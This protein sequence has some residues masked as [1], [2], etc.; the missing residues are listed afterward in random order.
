MSIRPL[1]RAADQVQESPRVLRYRAGD[2][3]TETP[4]PHRDP[5]D[6]DLVEYLFISLPSLTS[7]RFVANALAALEE[8][9]SIRILD[10]IV[11]VRKEDD[12]LEVFELDALEALQP[13][14]GRPRP[15]G[16]LLSDR[17]IKLLALGVKPATTGVIVVIESSWA[18]P[19]ARAART[20][21]GR[22]VAGERIP[23]PRFEAVRN[24]SS[25]DD[26]IE[27]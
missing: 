7:L 25:I 23:R 26:G 27:S 17:D 4:E 16:R 12:A 15:F 8:A 20:G 14:S 10:L 11:I 6:G 24:A 21:G 9:D 22:I 1:R 5:F 18:V 2:R 19:L 13:L 3:V